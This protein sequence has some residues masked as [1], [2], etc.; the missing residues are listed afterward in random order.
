MKKLMALVLSV[1]MFVGVP[2]P[3]YASEQFAEPQ[4]TEV[5]TVTNPD[6]SEMLSPEDKQ[7]DK[8]SRNESDI[9]IKDIEEQP[10]Q[11]VQEVVN[12]GVN[13]TNVGKLNPLFQDQSFNRGS[14]P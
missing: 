9:E 1:F 6:D 10:Q 7:E 5:E 11:E 13:Y 12:Y 3:V 14:G 8:S 2:F 4:N